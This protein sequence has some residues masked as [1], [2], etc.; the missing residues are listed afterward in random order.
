MRWI[1]TEEFNIK[2]HGKYR[3]E[4]GKIRK[5]SFTFCGSGALDSVITITDDLLSILPKKKKYD[6]IIIPIKQ[7]KELKKIRWREGTG[8]KIAKSLARGTK[9]WWDGAFWIKIIETDDTEHFI[10]VFSKWTN[11]DI[12][13]LEDIYD[14]LNSKISATS[15]DGI[16]CP[17]CGEK[18][19]SNSKFCMKCGNKI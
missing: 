16:F 12:N 13:L 5:S 15:I 18:I 7:I 6:D 4:E 14:F 8:S 1:K 11:F 17:Q 9:A 3:N 10:T 19:P 2:K